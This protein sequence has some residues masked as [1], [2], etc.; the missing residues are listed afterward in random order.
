MLATF[1]QP[2]MKPN[3]DV[4]RPTTVVTQALWFLNDSLI[5]E[6]A[7]DL[8]ELL[9]AT[10]P[11]TDA[12]L[13]ELFLRLFAEPPSTEEMDSSLSFLTTQSERFREHPDPEWQKTVQESPD[14]PKMRAMASLC[15]VLLASN[16]FLYVD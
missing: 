5:V 10:S 16:R 15:Q 12:Q 13:R 14:A 9:F 2:E 1:D 11:E 3:C 4:R 8:A 6:R 7:D